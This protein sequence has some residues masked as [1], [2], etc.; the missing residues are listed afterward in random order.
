MKLIRQVIGYKAFR[1]WDEDSGTIT[2]EDGFK[3]FHG[4]VTT[5]IQGEEFVEYEHVCYDSGKIVDT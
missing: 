4:F 5:V 3:M 2:N 1:E